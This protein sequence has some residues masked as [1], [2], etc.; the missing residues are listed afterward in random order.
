MWAEG[1]QALVLG[2]KGKDEPMFGCVLEAQ[3]GRP[4]G[5]YLGGGMGPCRPGPE[6]RWH[7]SPR[8]PPFVAEG[9]TQWG[10][11]RHHWHQAWCGEL[12]WR[13]TVEYMCEEMHC[14][15]SERE[16]LCFIYLIH[17][18]V[19]WPLRTLPCTSPGRNGS[20]LMRL[21]DACTMMW[22][23]RTLH[24]YLHWVRASPSPVT[25]ARLCILPHP[26]FSKVCSVLLTYGAWA[27]LVSPAFWVVAVIVRAGLFAL[28]PS[29]PVAPI[30]S[31]LNPHRDGFE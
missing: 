24:L 12:W 13:M 27:L 10:E 28:P 4:Q 21:R 11:I 30:Q 18:R 14:G 7:L 9:W 29:L 3:C 31:V 1:P 19:V 6:F 2:I 8:P 25:W 16:C 5:N 23:W 20:S 15:S 26:L 22:C 17:D